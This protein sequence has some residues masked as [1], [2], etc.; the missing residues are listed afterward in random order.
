MILP[1]P[2]G[3]P[4]GRLLRHVLFVSKGSNNLGFYGLGFGCIRWF[5]EWPKPAQID[6]LVLQAELSFV[7]E[8]VSACGM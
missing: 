4:A 8:G 7:V 6:S 2:G 5:H 1:G 3:T